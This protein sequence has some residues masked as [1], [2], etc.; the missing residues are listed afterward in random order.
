MTD[1]AGPE[2]VAS[3]EQI[4]LSAR[5]AATPP[6]PHTT[7]PRDAASWA[8]KVERLEVD[9]RQGVRGTNVAGRRL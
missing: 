8:K 4:G 5:E 2:R 7:A 1:T 3:A 6:V 9:P